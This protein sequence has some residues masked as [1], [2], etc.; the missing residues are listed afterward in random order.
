MLTCSF[1]GIANASVKHSPTSTIPCRQW[2]MVQ[3][4]VWSSSFMI[5]Q[6]LQNIQIRNDHSVAFNKMAYKF[7]RGTSLSLWEWLTAYPLASL[8]CIDFHANDVD[9]HGFRT[10]F[11]MFRRRLFECPWLKPFRIT[12]P[13]YMPSYRVLGL[14]VYYEFLGL[15]TQSGYAKRVTKTVQFA[16]PTDY[17]RFCGSF[18][19][20]QVQ[21]TCLF[22]AVPVVPVPYKF[23]NCSVD[24]WRLK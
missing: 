21:V 22:S 17:T 20:V 15:I 4:L 19:I 14:I 8:K 5:I 9:I 6:V 23:W 2:Q 3:Q 7:T 1:F 16:L 18:E 10:F 13:P 12:W 24:W 11:Y